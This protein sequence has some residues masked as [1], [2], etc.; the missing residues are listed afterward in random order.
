MKL[1]QSKE[2]TPLKFYKFFMY[3]WLPLGALSCL[4]SPFLTMFLYKNLNWYY[5]TLLVSCALLL[6]LYAFMFWGLLK[7]KKFTFA[8]FI[9]FLVLCLAITTLNV[10]YFMTNGSLPVY[11]FHMPQL[12]HD[13]SVYMLA[14]A[15][16]LTRIYTVV[17][18]IIGVALN[19]LVF[20]YFFNADS[21]STASRIKS[22]RTTHS[23][24]AAVSCDAKLPELRR[25]APVG[26]YVLLQL[27][28]R[29]DGSPR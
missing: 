22:R 29:Y 17:I 27:R 21:C 26:A 20:M 1:Y 23:V 6:I 14:F 8:L 11:S 16:T 19:F 18:S 10:I 15:E 24:S 9:V 7:W 2:T 28:K 5:V 25:A 3:V 13:S 4:Y 12:G